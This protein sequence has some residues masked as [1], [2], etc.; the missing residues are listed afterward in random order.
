MARKHSFEKTKYKNIFSLK[1]VAG[2]TEYYANFMLN[3]VSYQKKNFTK[4]FNCTTAKQASDTL[5]EVKS[6][7]RNGENPFNIASNRETIKSIVLEHINNK[8]PKGKPTAYKK[9]LE[10][11]YYN[12]VDPVIGHLKMEKVQDAHVDKIMK[13]I[14]TYR[15]EYQKNLQILMFKIFEKEFR[16][17]NISHNPFYDL[18]YGKHWKVP[19]FDTRLNEPVEDTARKLYR[20]ALEYNPKYRLFLLMTIM[21]A[22]RVG[23]IHKL[24]YGNI[25]QFSNGEWYILAHSDITKTEINEKYPLPEEVVRL[26]PEDV[27]AQK[28]QEK[29]LFNFSTSGIPLHW[30][31]LTQE[32]KV[33]INPGYKLTSHDCRKMFISI[34]SFDGTDTDLADRCLSHSQTGMKHT[35]LDVPFRVRKEVFESWWAFLRT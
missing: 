22:R 3:G 2:R 9:S 27:L 1:N 31:K 10:G 29:R 13:S 15:R 34:L 28:N 11:F 19:D 24:V 30:K 33:K 14:S 32:A 35:Y 18:D 16:K 4:L 12:Y 5:E 23:E 25:R 20:A 7:I 26:L 8:K 21:L 6:K 17:G